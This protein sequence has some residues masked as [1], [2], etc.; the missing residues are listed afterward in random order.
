MYSK[1]GA[2]LFDIMEA[3]GQE[4]FQ[5][6]ADLLFPLR[7]ELVQFLGG[8][9]AQKDLLNHIMIYSTIQC[10]EVSP[11]YKKLATQL[12][13]ERQNDMERDGS[14]PTLNHRLLALV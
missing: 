12:I 4:N 1:Y 2:Q 14:D 9:H 3:F 5:K 8:S 6:V 13:V 11:Y 7:H 10:Q